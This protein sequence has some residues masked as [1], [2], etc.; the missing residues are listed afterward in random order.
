MI[1]DSNISYNPSPIYYAKA[2]MDIS[3]SAGAMPSASIS[4]W[5]SEVTMTINVVYEIE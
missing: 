4:A 5:Q 1:N 2:E 3:D